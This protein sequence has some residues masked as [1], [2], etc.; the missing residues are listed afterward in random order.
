MN[1]VSFKDKD[2]LVTRIK[3][4]EDVD[5][6]DVILVSQGSG[7][8]CIYP[9]DLLTLIGLLTKVAEGE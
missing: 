8:V 9:E 2:D 5:A 1:N 6:G 3:Y 7:K 4:I